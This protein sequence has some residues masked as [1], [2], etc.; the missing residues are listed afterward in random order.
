MAESNADKPFEPT[1]HRLAKA[2]ERGDVPP[3][4]DTIGSAAVLALALTLI[5]VGPWA[6]VRFGLLLE[7]MVALAALQDRGPAV[8]A[9][10]WA[11]VYTLAPV[12]GAIVCVPAVVA[13]VVGFVLIGPVGS[14]EPLAPKFERLNP[15]EGLKRIVSL[16]GLFD[17]VKG[18]VGVA[19]IFAAGLVT[20]R[21]RLG[22]IASTWDAPAAAALASAASAVG[23]LLVVLSAVALL[24]SVPDLMFQRW[25]FRRQQR[26]SR[27]E[28]ER[29]M[30]DTDGNPEVK[31]E[32][33]RLRYE[34]SQ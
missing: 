16:K 1:Q 4:A 25:W 23:L 17:V 32:R 26:M 2:R 3:A 29:E 27:E 15:V 21:V 19:A 14:F 8:V 31:R 6:F 13:L 34:Q 22:P 9:A 20:L 28:L 18:L 7:R 5:V 30:K 24:V 12:V 10:L 11:F 33:M